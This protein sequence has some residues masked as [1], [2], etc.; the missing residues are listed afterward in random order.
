MPSLYII[1]ALFL[2]GSRERG[3]PVDHVPTSLSWFLE[4]TR[5]SVVAAEKP[6]EASPEQTSNGTSSPGSSHVAFVFFR[7]PIFSRERALKRKA[8]EPKTT[9]FQWLKMWKKQFVMAEHGE[10]ASFMI[11]SHP[12]EMIT[13]SIRGCFFQT[14]QISKKNGYETPFGPV[15]FGF[16]GRVFSRRIYVWYS[17]CTYCNF[18]SCLLFQGHFFLNGFKHPDPCWN[19]PIWRAYFQLGGATT[20]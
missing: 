11:W 12:T 4:P 18:M 5:G 6:L 3:R 8:L 1:M 19:N 7:C 10:T 13:I 2:W 15:R 16:E 9:S 17:H 14:Y 20:N